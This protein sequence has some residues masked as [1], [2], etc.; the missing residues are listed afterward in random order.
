MHAKYMVVDGPSGDGDVGE[1]EGV[2]LYANRG[3]GVTLDAAKVGDVL[4]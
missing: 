1:L 2:G 3:W 4:R